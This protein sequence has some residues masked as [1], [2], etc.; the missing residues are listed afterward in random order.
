MFGALAGIG[1]T[2]PRGTSIKTWC[3]GYLAIAIIFDVLVIIALLNKYDWLIETLLGL[4]AGAATGLGIHV[5]HHIL[6]EDG[7]E[8][9][10]HD[11]KE[12]TIFGF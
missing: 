9:H 11:G 7:N 6:E 10:E 5:A 4:A 8:Q 1:I 3:Y 12:K 2:Q